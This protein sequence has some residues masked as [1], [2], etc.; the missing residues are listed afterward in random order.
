MMSLVLVLLLFTAPV[1]ALPTIEG[2][3]IRASFPSGEPAPPLITCTAA[4]LIDADT[5]DYLFSHNANAR[6]PMASTTK[7]MTAVLALEA[8]KLDAKIKVSKNA[9]ATI[10]S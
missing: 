9:V 1:Y 10:G 3:T 5:G 2:W 6:L 8:L 4:F 7:I